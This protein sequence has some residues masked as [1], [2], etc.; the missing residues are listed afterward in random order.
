MAKTKVKAKSVKKEIKA[1]KAKIAKHEGKLKG[2][3][4]LLKKAK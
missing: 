2:L 4:K 1:R 3:K